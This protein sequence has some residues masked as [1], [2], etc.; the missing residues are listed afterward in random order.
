MKQPTTNNLEAVMLTAQ[1]S[2]LPEE[3]DSTDRDFYL[4]EHITGDNFPTCKRI[5]KYLIIVLCVK[6]MVKY[7]QN[8]KT[9]QAKVGD[10]I[11]LSS[12]HK[13]ANQQAFYGFEGTM[14]MVS[15]Q[16]LPLLPYQQMS[17][18]ALKKHLETNPIISLRQ[19]EM[20]VIQMNLKLLHSYITKH[21]GKQTIFNTTQVLFNE[22]IL[23]HKRTNPDES[24]KAKSDIVCRF[25]DLVEA[26]YCK[27]I[28]MD[29]CCKQLKYSPDK[30][31]KAIMEHFNITP[32]SYIMLKKLNY[33]FVCLMNTK[34]KP[35][36]REIAERLMFVS[37]SA[38]CRTF[39]KYTHTTPLQFY[40]LTLGQQQ[41]IIRRTI[42]Y[43]NFP[44]TGLPETCTPGDSNPPLS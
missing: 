29:W 18:Q 20:E 19:D 30:L 32:H 41:D 28:N 31:T 6:G 36:I 40:H 3:S 1:S 15:E 11:I 38:F 9:M 2:I 44:L 8:D 16:M 39:K 25:Q 13:V 42:P 23:S 33:S 24:D 27:R 17:Y 43:Q 35:C 34:S 5:V 26:N 4:C 37:E 14:L 22:F 7:E 10:L 21:N 12:A